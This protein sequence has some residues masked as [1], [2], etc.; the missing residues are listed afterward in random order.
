MLDEIR[1]L[2]ALESSGTISEAA[3][4]LRLTQSAVTK[5]IKALE[6]Q[7]GYD[8]TEPEGRKLRLTDRGVLFLSK[9]RPLLLEIEALRDLEVP[10]SNRTL[11][12][13]L[14]DS[15]ASSWGPKVLKDV[16]S[17][18]KGLELEIHVHRSTLIIEQLRSGRYELGL[19]TGPLQ[20]N[21]LIW[22]HL[23]DESMVLVGNGRS[24]K[25]LTIENISATWKEIGGQAL[26]HTSL[27]NKKFTHVESFCA[28]IQMARQGFGQALV[29]VG[30][31]RTY[32]LKKAEQTAM[33]PQ[34]KRQIHLVCR[35][36][37]ANLECVK[38]LGQLLSVQGVYN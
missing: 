29:P 32:G 20:G 11:R 7:L 31:A 25:V 27:K 34:L 12:I 17:K 4:E 8:L 36:S 15:I 24:E 26:A 10:E 2:I 22:R 9:A 13:G 5:R 18:M 19:V 38:D 14:S 37:V 6:A 30:L 3:I 28:A 23:T 35:K 1:A 21:D 16:L 33:R